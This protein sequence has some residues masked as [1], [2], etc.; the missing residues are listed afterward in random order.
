MK[1]PKSTKKLKT[2]ATLFITNFMNLIK[3]KTRFQDFKLG[4]IRAKTSKSTHKSKRTQAAGS[5]KSTSGML[6][7]DSNIFYF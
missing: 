5:C 4:K 3:R 7:P 6:I 2:C 1:L